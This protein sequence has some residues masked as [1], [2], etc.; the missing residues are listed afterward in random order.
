M[1]NTKPALDSQAKAIKY[2]CHFQNRT[3]V[4]DP[5]SDSKIIRI[6]LKEPSQ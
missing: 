4:S 5:S 1:D 6:K 2:A 3:S